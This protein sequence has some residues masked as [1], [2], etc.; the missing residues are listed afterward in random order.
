MDTKFFEEFARLQS[1][2]NRFMEH[3]RNVSKVP[4]GFSTAAW[5]PQV[6]IYDRG[7]AFV[8]LAELPGVVPDNLR[9]SV[10]D[11]KVHIQGVK[12]VPEPVRAT[13]CRH[14]EISFGPFTRTVP[15]PEPVATE[16]VEA[17]LRN[18]LLRLVVPKQARRR[19]REIPIQS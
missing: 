16:G 13:R 3:L 14:M 6:N 1:E 2:M 18:G 12:E 11:N 10:L 19:K 9:V 8:V 7:H 4:A 5:V 15:L 17:E